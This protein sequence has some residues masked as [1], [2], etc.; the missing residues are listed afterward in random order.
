MA[1]NYKKKE[2]DPGPKKK[3]LYTKVLTDEQADKLDTWLDK[4]L[5]APFNVDY[6]KFAY[7]GPDVNVVAYTSG[8]LVIQGKGM[9][10]FVHFV[11]EPE[12]TGAF[13]LG[14]D[15]VK[16]PE[17]YTAHAGVDESGKGDLFGPLVSAC[18]VADGDAVREWVAADLKESKAVSSDAAVLSMAKKI[19]NTKGVVVKVSYANMEKYNALYIKVGRNLNKL[20]AWMHANAI[21]SALEERH[22]PWGMLDQFTKQPLVQKHLDIPGFELKMQT[23]AEADPVVAAASIIARAT[24]IYAMQKLSTEFGGKLLKGSS[25]KVRAQAVEIVKKFGPEGLKRF[26]KLHF[27]TATE[28]LQ[29]ARK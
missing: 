20:L 24:Y 2:L 6:A 27:K 29:E 18:V 10:D 1:R 17:W 9:E 5:W 12:I 22:V 19:K 11:L 15:D 28:A 21:K 7:K 16:H 4:H 26:A 25:D 3:T 14:Y 23:K 8:K 13:E